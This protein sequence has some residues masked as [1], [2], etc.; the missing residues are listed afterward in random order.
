MG[1]GNALGSDE[2]A[3]GYAAAVDLHQ[4]LLGFG[5]HPDRVRNLAQTFGV[6]LFEGGDSIV[7]TA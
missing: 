2:L 7:A 6:P 1:P 4:D 3:D 5:P